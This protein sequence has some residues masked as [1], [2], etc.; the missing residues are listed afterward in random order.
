[1]D[2]SLSNIGYYTLRFVYHTT[3]IRKLNDI[4]KEFHNY[5]KQTKPK[6]K[7][8]NKGSR[9]LTTISNVP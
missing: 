6:L 3:M 8:M 2:L 9:N 5:F 7:L 4:S 1:M